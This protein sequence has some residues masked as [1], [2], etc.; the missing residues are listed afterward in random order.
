MEK[1]ACARDIRQIPSPEA[2]DRMLRACVG[3]V[4]LLFVSCSPDLVRRSSMPAKA[5]EALEA[6][7]ILGARHGE[8]AGLA[9]P[10]G[11]CLDLRGRVYVADTGNDRIVVFSSQGD[12]LY[13]FGHRG[14]R[15]GEFDAPIDVAVVSDLVF[16]VD[17]GNERIQTFGRDG[18]P[19]GSVSIPDERGPWRPAGLVLGS[20]GALYFSDGERD[21]VVGLNRAGQIAFEIGGF[22]HWH[23]QLDDPRGVEVTDDQ[24][25]YVADSGNG[26]VEIFDALGAWESSL[27][28][29]DLVMPWDVCADGMGNLFVS[30]AGSDRVCVYGADGE[31][32]FSVGTEGLRSGGLRQPTGIAFDGTEFIYVADKGND[33]IQVFRIVY[34]ARNK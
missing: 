25:L 16:V 34:K 23:G 15:E 32:L 33:R 18:D 6:V 29:G 21:R 22:G 3:I 12:L 14:W 1:M 13:E 5:P 30:D 26:R 10:E 31:F 27:V 4:S 9:G 28:G 19:R 24:R 20:A 11:V 17:W 8:M 2:R 7:R